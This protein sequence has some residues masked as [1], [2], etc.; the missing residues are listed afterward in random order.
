[1][2]KRAHTCLCL[3]S[4]EGRPP[5]LPP[6][7][8][9]SSCAVAPT[10]SIPKSGSSP[11]ALPLPFLGI[12]N[13]A[14]TKG[15]SVEL[16]AG[17]W[18]CLGEQQGAALGCGDRER[19]TLTLTLQSTH[20]RQVNHHNC[21]WMNHGRKAVGRRRGRKGRELEV[22]FAIQQFTSWTELGQPDWV[23]L[24]FCFFVVF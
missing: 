7:C 6:W 20:L 5:S 8:A 18:V 21:L 16:P 10:R 23:P 11:V 22:G 15:K 9:G 1:M 4:V 2:W 24:R 13:M 14:W 12:S 17:C 3:K 19:Q